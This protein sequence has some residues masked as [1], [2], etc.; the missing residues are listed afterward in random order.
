LPAPRREAPPAAVRHLLIDAG[1]VLFAAHPGRAFEGIAA[2]SGR[3]ASEIL[4]GVM[5]AAKSGF[6]RGRI[7][8]P[9]FAAELN[10]ATRQDLSE[11]EWREIWC[12]IF[13]DLSPMQA[14][15]TRLARD[16][17]CYLFS[18]TDPWHLAWFRT[19]FPAL[20]SFRG[21]HPSFEAGCA[22]P[23][24]RYYLLGFERFGLAPEQCLLIDDRAE[25]VEA[26]T[27]LGA[28][29]IVHRNAEE[30]EAALESFGIKA[31]IEAEIG[32]GG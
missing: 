21:V 12:S 17:G 6:D 18:N 20:A 26:V 19:R 28:Q 29:G 5:D 32:A 1:G 14:L 24:P 13:E 2:R 8:G 15:V 31:G 27:V 3:P 30:T 4:G 10:R 23:D 7:E 11:E 9:A 22:K 16:H 25:N